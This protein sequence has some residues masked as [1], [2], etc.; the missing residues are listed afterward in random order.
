V[1]KVQTG[2]GLLP[3]H[4]LGLCGAGAHGDWLSGCADTGADLDGDA[5][6][7]AAPTGD[8]AAPTSADD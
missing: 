6:S 3:G 1:D 5:G 4:P 2:P 7:D 8:A